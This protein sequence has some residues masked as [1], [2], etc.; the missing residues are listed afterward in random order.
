MGKRLAVFWY[1]SLLLQ[2]VWVENAKK[3]FFNEKGFLSV[4]FFYEI[5]VYVVTNWC[6]RLEKHYKL[7]ICFGL[8][9]DSFFKLLHFSRF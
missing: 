9:V 3:Y 6:T 5:D 2:I 4:V 7:K 1:S 8:I